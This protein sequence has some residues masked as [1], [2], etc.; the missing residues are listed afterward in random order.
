M[1][2]VV[3]Q[4]SKYESLDEESSPDDTRGEE[5]SPATLRSSLIYSHS[6]S[7][8][9]DILGELTNICICQF[10]Q[11]IDKYRDGNVVLSAP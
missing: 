2:E 8:S 4:A 9:E 6:V 10:S 11:Y 3:C 1:K 7:I 5:G